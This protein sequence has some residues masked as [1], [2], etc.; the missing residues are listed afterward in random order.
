MSKQKRKNNTSRSILPVGVAKVLDQMQ[1]VIW[2][3]S[4]KIHLSKDS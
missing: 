2:F 3:W 4:G 1:I